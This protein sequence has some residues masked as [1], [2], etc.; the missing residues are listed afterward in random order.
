M[1]PPDPFVCTP[2][3]R[4]SPSLCPCT[5]PSLTS[6]CPSQVTGGAK[7]LSSS[8]SLDLELA[9]GLGWAAHSTCPGQVNERAG[10]SDGVR[11]AG[12]G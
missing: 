8:H 1:L 2:L 10:C 3:A 11:A 5:A 12:L 4:A 7:L 9:V 6:A